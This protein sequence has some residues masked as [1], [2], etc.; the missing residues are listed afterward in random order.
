CKKHPDIIECF[1]KKFYGTSKILRKQ[2]FGKIVICGSQPSGNHHNVRA[3]FC[4]FKGLEDGIPVVSHRRPLYYLNAYLVQLLAYP[5]T[6]GL[7]DLP[8]HELVANGQHL[9][10][11]YHISAKIG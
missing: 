4:R 10:F 11:Y 6:V 1:R 9:C 3:S 5:V 7:D 2:R 8:V